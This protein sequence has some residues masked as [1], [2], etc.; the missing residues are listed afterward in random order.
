M[1]PRAAACSLTAA[2]SADGARFLGTAD[3]AGILAVARRSGSGSDPTKRTGIETGLDDST[4]GRGSTFTASGTASG[5]NP[6][7]P[8]DGAGC[9]YW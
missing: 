8:R 9:W 5:K 1:N 2:A 3:A 7:T 6:L 4:L